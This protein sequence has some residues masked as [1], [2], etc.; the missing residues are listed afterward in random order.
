MSL[1]TPRASAGD[2]NPVFVCKIVATL[3]NPTTN[4]Y[5]YQIIPDEATA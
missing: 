2:T 5:A 1:P 4:F 3:T